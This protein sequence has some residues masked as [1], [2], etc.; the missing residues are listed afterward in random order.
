MQG[1]LVASGRDGGIVH[2][3]DLQSGKVLCRTPPGHAGT[4]SAS[5]SVRMA[6][7]WPAAAASGMPPGVQARGR[8]RSGRG[9]LEAG[10]GRWMISALGSWPELQPGRQAAGHLRRQGEE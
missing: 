4:S 9:D 7:G 2:V 3:W 5:P 8:S 10:S 6:S 1:T